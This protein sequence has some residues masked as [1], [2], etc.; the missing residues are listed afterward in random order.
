MPDRSSQKL[1]DLLQSKTVVTL[2][3]MQAAL[4]GASRATVFRY[5]AK[6]QYRRSYNHNGRHYTLYQPAR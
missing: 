4:Q 1:F 6:I 3:D 2:S 5:L